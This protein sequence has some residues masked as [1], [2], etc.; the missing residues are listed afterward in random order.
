MRLKLF[1]LLA[2][3]AVAAPLGARADISGPPSVPTSPQERSVDPVV[4]TGSQFPG[5]SAGPEVVAHEPGSPLNSDT[6]GQ[7]A[8]NPVGKSD[9]YDPDANPYDENDNGDHSCVQ[10]SRLPSA[11]NTV[12]DAVNGSLNTT[13]GADVDRVVGFRWDAAK[14]RFVQ[15]PLQVD[16]KFTRF[17][18]NNASGFAIY[19]GVDQETNYAFDREGFRYSSDQSRV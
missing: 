8:N 2:V 12:G 11:N 10:E 5:W 14:R 17:I 3:A 1:V 4:L 13:I 9:C 7:E 6:A 16:E 19:S 18:S 15:F